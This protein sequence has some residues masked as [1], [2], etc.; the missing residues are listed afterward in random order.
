MRKFIVTVSFI[1]AIIVSAVLENQFANYEKNIVTLVLSAVFF[2][3][4]A[5][6][7]IYSFVLFH[8]TFPERYKLFVA[9]TVN[10]KRLSLD[11]IKAEEKYYKKKFKR[12][13]FKEKFVYYCQIALSLGAGIALIVAIFI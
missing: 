8:K 2:F 1:I 11:I 5:G 10:K 6:E 9:E 12:T 3:Y 7:F 4:W 13:L